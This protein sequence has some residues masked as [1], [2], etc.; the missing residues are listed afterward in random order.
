MKT[1]KIIA[2]LCSTLLI[3]AFLTGCNPFTLGQKIS[4]SISGGA[5]GPTSV[6]VQNSEYHEFDDDIEDEFEED[7][8][9]NLGIQVSVDTEDDD[10]DYNFEDIDYD[11]DVDEDN[12]DSFQIDI[13][14]YDDDEEDDY[15]DG[16]FQ[17]VGSV[18]HGY[19]DVPADYLHF[20][21]SSSMNEDDLLQYSD[22]SGVNIV[23]LCYFE[24][25]DAETIA[26]TLLDSFETDTGLDQST[27]TGAM[28]E[29]DGCEAYQVYGYYPDYNKYIVIW[30]LDS[31]DDNYIHYIAV[32]FTPDNYDLFELV[33]DTYHVLY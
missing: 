5:D 1:N 15:D 18:E 24:N 21:D 6:I 11:D 14:D 30:I 16:E 29:L 8:D 32:E 23:T 2:I 3:A 10:N 28:V 12:D 9:D 4:Q 33:E 22:P 31:P 7:S 25:M 20:V 17:R 13:Q 26:Y 19:V 27:V